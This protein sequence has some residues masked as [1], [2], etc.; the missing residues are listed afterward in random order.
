MLSVAFHLGLVGT[1][2]FGHLLSSP[3]KEPQA[4]AL[5]VRFISTPPAPEPPLSVRLPQVTPFAPI[6]IQ[7]PAA[8]SLPNDAELM[9][10]IHIQDESDDATELVE[11]PDQPS[12]PSDPEPPTQTRGS[13]VELSQAEQTWEAQVLAALERKKRYPAA[14]LRHKDEDTVYVHITIDRTGRVLDA[15]IERSVGIRM[16]DEEAVQLA[17]R[18]SP[19]PSPPESVEGERIELVIPVEFFIRNGRFR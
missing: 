18:A 13:G 14:A 17:H 15:R 8:P 2:A 1:V 10:S 4:S 16:L 9:N 3:S 12:L 7:P 19:L 6:K 5:E 11:S